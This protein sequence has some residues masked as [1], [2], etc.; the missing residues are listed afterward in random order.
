MPL[1]T[2]YFSP[3]YDSPN[4]SS[5]G[6]KHGVWSAVGPVG[7]KRPARL[8]LVPI[9]RML[10]FTLYRPA[11]REIRTHTD[12]EKTLRPARSGLRMGRWAGKN[13][14]AWLW[15]RVLLNALFTLY[16]PANREI[17]THTDVEKTLRPAEAGSAL[18]MPNS[19]KTDNHQP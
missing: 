12:V 2:N 3:G 5:C 4:S 13:L 17:R 8:A 18:Q 9:F 19:L 7:R 11:N 6:R 14:H 1:G 10:H 15:F 16:Q